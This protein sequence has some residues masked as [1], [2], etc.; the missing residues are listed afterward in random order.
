MPTREQDAN[1]H[2]RDKDRAPQDLTGLL[3][4]RE[5]ADQ[6]KGSHRKS[7]YDRL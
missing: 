7:K 5:E 4:S 1:T 3:A 6:E 2:S